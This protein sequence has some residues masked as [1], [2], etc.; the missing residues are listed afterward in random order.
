MSLSFRENDPGSVEALLNAL[1]PSLDTINSGDGASSSTNTTQATQD[2]HK[3]QSTPPPQRNLEIDSLLDLLG[4]SPGRQTQT[5]QNHD[6]IET[7]RHSYASAPM[8]MPISAPVSAS[9]PA[10][11]P[12]PQQHHQPEQTNPISIEE[13]TQIRSMTFPQ[14][15]MLIPTLPAEKTE[16]LK[17]IQAQQH[18][19]EKSL[20]SEWSVM[21]SKHVNARKELDQ[22][23][24]L[25]RIDLSRDVSRLDSD[26][27]RR[28]DAFKAKAQARWYDLRQSQQSQLEALHIPCFYQTDD[29]GV[30]STQAKILNAILSQHG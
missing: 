10:P 27:K 18:R 29:S 20:H 15:L 6:N 22:K 5:Q 25:A 7:R 14:A 12:Q 3:I 13:A 24:A 23:M 19:I 16:K 30:L 21:N 9:A 8:P 11:A 26:F 2:S 28:E 1:K 17:K 4:T